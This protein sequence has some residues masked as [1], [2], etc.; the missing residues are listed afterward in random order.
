MKY[1]GPQLYMN[2][3]YSSTFIEMVIAVGPQGSTS[4]DNVAISVYQQSYSYIPLYQSSHLQWRYLICLAAVTKKLWVEIHLLNFKIAYLI[5]VHVT[6]ILNW[7]A[8]AP[9]KFNKKVAI[10]VH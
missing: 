3:S 7:E 4:C 5:I 10:V 8:R 6:F 9:W 1:V 2:A